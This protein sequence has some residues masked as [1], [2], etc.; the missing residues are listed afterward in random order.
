M[1]FS[2][3]LITDLSNGKRY[4][5][6][7]TAETGMLLERWS[8][9]SKNGH[10]GNVELRDL[11]AK[12]GIEHVQQYFQYSILENYN[13]RT[14]DQVILDRESWWKDAL[15]SRRYGYNSN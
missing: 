6:S 5:S 14:D 3:F 1:H 9:Y 4:V 7:A 11:V 15:D 12:R 2:V 8:A 10:G 13:Q